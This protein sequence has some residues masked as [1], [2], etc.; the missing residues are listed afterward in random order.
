MKRVVADIL[1]F[2]RSVLSD[3]LKLTRKVALTGLAIAGGFVALAQPPHAFAA[4]SDSLT[5]VIR[6]LDTNPPAAITD[7]QA[8]PGAANQMLLQWTAPDEN[9]NIYSDINPT[10]SYVIRIA[11]FSADSVGSTTTW[12]NSATDVSGEP[13]PANPGITEYLL[14]NGLPG[15][16]TYYIAIVSVDDVGLTSPIDTNTSTVGQQASAF[17]I[18][19]LGSPPTN[20]QGIGLSTISIQWNWDITPGA[21]D[22][23]LF[24]YPSDTFITNTN[25]LSLIETGFTPN[26]PITRTLRSSNASGLSLPTSPVTVY[27]LAQVPANLAVTGIGPTGISLSWT[28]NNNPGGTQ[29]RLERSNNGVAYVPIV[30]QTTTLYQDAGLVEL[31]TYYYRVRA[32]NGDGLFTSPSSVVSAFTTDQG[33]VILPGAPAGL[34]GY[35]DP[36]GRAFTL[37]WETV[38]FNVDGTPITDLAGY[39]IYRRDTLTGAGIKITPAPLTAPAFAD[40]VNGG[41]YYYTVRAVDRGGNESEHSLIADSSVDANIIYLG[42]DGVSHVMMPESVNDL[43]R[44]AYNKYGVPLTINLLEEPLTSDNTIIRNVRLQLIRVDTGVVLEDLAFAKPQSVISVG[45]NTLSGQVARGAPI[46]SGQPAQA[47]GLTPDQLSLYWFN[48]VTWVKIG[49]TLDL[50]SQSLRTKSSFL[51]NYQ[52][53]GVASATSLALSQGNVYPRLFTPNGDGRNDRVYFVLE[54]PN[55]V[56]VSGKIMD[57]DGRHVR[58]LPPPATQ[59]GIGTTLS[60][61]GKDDR[62]NVVP[63]GAYIYQIQGE[64][65]NFTG[66]VGV[67]R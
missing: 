9:N 63:G 4:V 14:L 3:R 5:V 65:K 28:S 48:G 1:E 45:Y 15:G 55:N 26:V 22:Y 58:T 44:S 13:I 46:A 50:N 7:L 35:L 53:R 60:W 31:T 30:T 66:T 39:Y 27:T 67:A 42:V 29:Y 40:Q 56:S 49:G 59:A 11:T 19:S 57:K 34:K 24:N 43:L 41:V 38:Q 12:W 54:N 51:G 52:I 61:D 33:D 32:I 62:G 37:L 6:P 8:T 47:T 20:F 23:R 2:V 64:G 25:A 17:V 36:T 21:T 16:V 10:A 18:S